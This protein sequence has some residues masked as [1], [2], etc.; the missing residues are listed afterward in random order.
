[1]TEGFSISL[2]SS[3]LCSISQVHD[4][5][6]MN[7]AAS[8]N[9]KQKQME[10]ECAWLKDKLERMIFELTWKMA[11]S[12]CMWILQNCTRPRQNWKSPA[13]FHNPTITYYLT[14]LSLSY[15]LRKGWLF[16]SPLKGESVSE[17]GGV[18]V[19]WNYPSERAVP[20]WVVFQGLGGWENREGVKK[21]ETEWTVK[22]SD[23]KLRVG[24]R[25]M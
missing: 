18:L 16:V 20:N 14:I 22:E 21:G 17:G 10:S 11:F 6:C 12:C 5:F 24:K 4:Y 9:S 2:F 7:V 3:S 23:L 13:F 1:M 15:R 8:V 25:G 19:K